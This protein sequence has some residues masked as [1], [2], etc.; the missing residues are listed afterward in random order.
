MFVC[1][2]CCLRDGFGND[3]CGRCLHYVSVGVFHGLFRG[4]VLSSRPLPRPPGLRE[5][6][7]GLGTSY[8]PHLR[9]C[10]VGES[11]GRCK[12]ESRCASGFRLCGGRQGHA[13]LAWG[14]HAGPGIDSYFLKF[15]Y[16]LYS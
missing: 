16:F 4:C 3:S 1:C 2:C 11:T 15:L 6:L 8:G 9:I 14:S 12:L 10:G 7:R 5:S 13:F